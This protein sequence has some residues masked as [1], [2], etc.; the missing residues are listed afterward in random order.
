M[1]DKHTN[2]LISD[3][4]ILS[5]RAME[6]TRINIKSSFPKLALTGIES[7]TPH[8]APTEQTVGSPRSSADNEMCKKF[9][10]YLLVKCFM[11]YRQS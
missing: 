10:Y 8:P 11:T 7:E 2:K 9:L 5:N 6:E 3:Q 1:P 4:E